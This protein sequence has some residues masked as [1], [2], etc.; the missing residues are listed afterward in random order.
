MLTINSIEVVSSGM[1]LYARR[2]GGDSVM[3]FELG[4]SIDGRQLNL[5]LSPMQIDTLGE[6]LEKIRQPI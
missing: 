3:E 6:F 2:I 4:I 5:T 1:T